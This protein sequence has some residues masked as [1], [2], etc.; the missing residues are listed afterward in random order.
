M[1]LSSLSI[2]LSTHAHRQGV[3]ISF[4]VCSFFC[5]FVCVCVCTVTDFSTE[6]KASSFKFCMVVHWRPG[7][8]ISHFGELCSPRSPKSNESVNARATPASG[9]ISQWCRRRIDMRGNTTA[10]EDGSSCSCILARRP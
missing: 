3:D 4:T 7:Q 5:N 2:L 1:L 9:N 6:D 10:Q 8:G